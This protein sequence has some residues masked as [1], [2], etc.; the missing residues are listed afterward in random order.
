MNDVAAG[1]GGL[2]I[3]EV[4]ADDAAGLDLVASLH[5]ELLGFGTMAG[6]GHEFVREAC[7]RANMIGGAL[8]VFVAEIDGEAAGFAAVT[9][10]ARSFH[11]HGLAGQKGR[12]AWHTAKAL[13]AKPSRMAALL[14]SLG[15]LGSRREEQH[16]EREPGEVV[17]IAG[18]QKYLTA[19]FTRA[20]GIRLS[21]ALVRH[22]AAYLLRAGTLKMRMLV[23]ADNRP[24]LMLYHFLGAQFRDVRL[25]ATP[26]VEVTFDL[27]TG[28]LASPA[29]LPAA[30]D[31][32]RAT[33]QADDWRTYWETIDERKK[34]FRVEARDHVERLRRLVPLDKSSR[35]LDFGCGFGFVAEELAPHVGCVGLWDAAASVRRRAR[36]RTAQLDNVELADPFEPGARYDLI[37][38]HSVVQYMTPDEIREWLERWRA[39]LRTPGRLV[40]SD[41]L[42]PETSSPRELARYLQ[43]AARSGFFV[44]AFVEGVREIARYSRARRARPLTVVTPDQ[45]A[46]WGSAAGYR[47]D[48]L[49]ENL[50]Y[51]AS[52]RTAVLHV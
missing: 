12:V 16:E 51:R 24:V 33:G 13:V 28:R 3:R 6:L 1:D 39:L 7:Y 17:C 43:F 5:M 10:L 14:R 47:V 41:L 18:R 49:P 23:T 36:L 40:L 22:C 4:K 26:N 27:A 2:R 21:E 42:Q 29:P 8:R 30:W 37:T 9:P 38:A 46:A 19:R 35:V 31:E 20:R 15:E 52:R 34:V 25:G 11:R 50:S 32:T 44:D 45:I 48:I